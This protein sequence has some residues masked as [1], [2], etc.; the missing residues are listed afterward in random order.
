MLHPPILLT[1]YIVFAFH[2]KIL[3]PSIQFQSVLI[4]VIIVFG[5]YILFDERAL[6]TEGTGIWLLFGMSSSMLGIITWLAL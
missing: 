6:K 2:P 1:G 5:T 4:A 3:I